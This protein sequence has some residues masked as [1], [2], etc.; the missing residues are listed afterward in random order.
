MK[1][2]YKYPLDV[3]GYVRLMLPVGAKILTAQVQ[4]NRICLWVEVETEND[5]DMRRLWILGTGMKFPL[6]VDLRYIATVQQGMFV[7]H[8]HEEN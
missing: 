1:T 2:I 5:L 8:V 7:W 3:L 4:N 6:D